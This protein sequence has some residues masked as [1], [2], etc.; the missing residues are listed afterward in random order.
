MVEQEGRFLAAVRVLR[1]GDVDIDSADGGVVRKNGNYVELTDPEKKVLMH[2]AANHGYP[3]PRDETV[4]MVLRDEPRSDGLYGRIVRSLRE[5]VDGSSGLITLVN[6]DM[7]PAIRF[8]PRALSSGEDAVKWVRVEDLAID[9]VGGEV[10]KNGEPIELTAL[11]WKALKYSAENLGRF[12]PNVEVKRAI[13]GT[14]NIHHAT[15]TSFIRGLRVSIGDDLVKPRLLASVHFG[16]VHGLCFGSA[17]LAEELRP[18]GLEAGAVAQAVAPGGQVPEAGFE[19]GLDDAKARALVQK[20]ARELLD[21]EKTTA[22][23]LSEARSAGY[24]GSAQTFRSW[25]LEAKQRVKYEEGDAPSLWRERWKQKG[26]SDGLLRLLQKSVEDLS[27]GNVTTVRLFDTAKESFKYDKSITNFR[28]MVSDLVVA[29]EA[30][31]DP[32]LWQSAPEEPQGLAG[33]DGPEGLAGAV[34]PGVQVAE[35]A[36]GSA[37]EVAEALGFSGMEVGGAGSGEGQLGAE[38]WWNPDDEVDLSTPP[39]PGVLFPE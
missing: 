23:L 20:N 19:G 10:R 39:D 33:G 38:P 9:V 11:Q 28:Y 35:A 5:K 24:S 7:G 14:G 8:G 15:Y 27:A 36:F 30:K 26:V 22:Q 18:Q 6:T 31:P 3:V 21:G 17:E 16:R 2:W 34:E 13:W 25:V 4:W 1:V 37:V 32:A 29:W 12:L